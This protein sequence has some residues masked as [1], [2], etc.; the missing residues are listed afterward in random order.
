MNT[1]PAVTV[2]IPCYNKEKSIGRAIIS[3]MGQTFQNFEAFVINDGS[4][5][6]SDQVIRRLI[7]N[8]RRFTYI[9]QD[10][11]GVANAR[12]KGVFM[13]TGKY[14]CCLDGDDAMAPT[15]LEVCVSEL[16]KNPFI[17]IAYTG[18]WFIRPDGSEGLSTWP[19]EY[20][21]D[22]QLKGRNQIPTCNVSRRE[23][24]ERLGGQR[25]RYAPLGAG[26]EDAEMWLRAG[27]IGFRA[28]KVTD[29]GLFVYSWMSGIVSGNK[30]HKATDW[31]AWHPWTR[32]GQ[33][34]FA[35]AAKP[36]NGFSHPVRQ[37]D[38]P[39]VSIVI[40]VG[41]GHSA[42]LFD[43]VDS[44]EAQTFRRWET[45]IV[46]DGMDREQEELDIIE[47]I[48][49]AYPFVKFIKIAEKHGAGHAR[50]EG[51]KIARSPLLMFLDADD[52]LTPSA[53]EEMVIEH[54]RTGDVIYTD[55]YGQAFIDKDSAVSA[56]GK[57]LVAYN[58]ETGEAMMHYSSARFDCKR[59]QS[60]P[61]KELYIWCLITC[62]FPRRYH[63]AIGGFD[64]DMESWEDWDY[65]IRIAK[66]GYCF[67]RIEVPLV[68]Y[69][70]YTGSRR[71]TGLQKY[72]SLIEHMIDKYKDISMA[73]CNCKKN[74]T[75]VRGFSQAQTMSSDSEVQMD[76]SMVLCKYNHPNLGQ[77]MVVG[78][79]TG[80][81]YGYYGGGAELYVHKKDI[82]IS[83]DLFIP[84]VPTAQVIEREQKPVDE[85]KPISETDVK[86]DAVI[87]KEPDLLSIP[88]KR[89][90]EYRL[91]LSTI[92]GILEE[93][94]ML[95]NTMGIHSF[96][97][98]VAAGYSSLIRIKGIGP[99][100]ASDVLK[101][102]K[103]AIANNTPEDKKERLK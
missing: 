16:E 7:A 69:R 4:T 32:D 22:E 88:D 27:A 72:E 103:D 45:I 83:G 66:A 89:T 52:W 50:N 93:T 76:D 48:E 12:N 40:P 26:E 77:H 51:C 87:G 86:I 5:D 35:S 60:Q 58:D 82:A 101:Y 78:V 80:K 85:P 47:R 15:F 8:N 98:V 54:E 96:G 53:I 36:T 94:A 37:Y 61:T 90:G 11:S 10:N 14:V 92:P 44:I 13:G 84:I 30:K 25:Q 67:S 79:A 42:Q 75:A 74:K 68:G 49:K 46:F 24:W 95:M 70:F 19:G 59:A 100:R 6:G 21:Y 62:L 3:V 28:K 38:E 102:V 43:A 18:L 29:E 63:E 57:R 2:V 99:K 73:P 34:P 1:R 23:V 41:I 64:E 65:W 55:Y 9:H 71:D 91:D 97:D 17:G 31:L 39:M 81:R 56:Y 33:H 20:D